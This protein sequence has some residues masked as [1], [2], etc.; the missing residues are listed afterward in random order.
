MMTSNPNDERVAAHFSARIGT[1]EID[2]EKVVEQGLAIHPTNM[3]ASRKRGIKRKLLKQHSI[4]DPK[5]SENARQIAE[6]TLAEG[7]LE[8][9]GLH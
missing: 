7:G 8:Y 1:G 5:L 3:S 6:K 9:L 4:L 2:I